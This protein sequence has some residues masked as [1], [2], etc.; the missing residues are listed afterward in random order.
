MN[1]PLR[2]ELE[3]EANVQP[4]PDQTPGEDGVLVEMG[5]VS[6]TQGGFLGPKPDVGGGFQAF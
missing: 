2:E 4:T 6:N 3:L 1:T 5:R